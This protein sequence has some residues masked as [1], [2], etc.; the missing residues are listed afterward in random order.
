L[1]NGKGHETLFANQSHQQ[2]SGHASGHL[3]QTGHTFSQTAMLFNQDFN[4]LSESQLPMG[5]AVG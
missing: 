4:L 2:L 3:I 5:R 1:L